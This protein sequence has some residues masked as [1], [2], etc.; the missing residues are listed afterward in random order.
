MSTHDDAST[1]Q[2]H[3][4]NIDSEDIS[5]PDGVVIDFRSESDLVQDR[6]AAHAEALELEEWY[7]E[8]MDEYRYEMGERTAE[9]RDDPRDEYDKEITRELMDAGLLEPPRFVKPEKLGTYETVE[10]GGGLT[11]SEVME[12]LV[13]YNERYNGQRRETTAGVRLDVGRFND[14]ARHLFYR[15]KLNYLFGKGGSGKTNLLLHVAAE[16]VMNREYVVWL[17]FEEITPTELQE[18]MVHQGVP[19]A[20][21]YRYFLP[22]QVTETWAPEIQGRASLVVIDS[23]N[24]CMEFLGV[25]PMTDSGAITKLVTTYFN[26][27]RDL[28]PDMTG[29]VI[30]HVGLSA[31]AQ[32]RPSGHHSK[33][34]KFQGAVYRLAPMREGVEGDW[35]YSALYLAKDNKRKTGLRT[36]EK[37]GYVLMDSSGESGTLDVRI[38]AEEPTGTSHTPA[39]EQAKNKTANGAKDIAERILREQTRISDEDW[40]ALIMDELRA[41]NEG[42]E[43]P[44]LRVRMRKAVSQLKGAEVAVQDGDDWVYAPTVNP[45]PLG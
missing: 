17:I 43:D 8:T 9:L 6:E 36:G 28:N 10:I 44:A 45:I 3:V 19:E 14:S 5:G 37:A 16:F 7:W 4:E 21:V 11:H 31:N 1:G 30:D 23:A 32:D 40:R 35:G 20:L 34:D 27:Y 42:T 18:M 26:P 13:R 25:N 15:T 24:P 39:G 33:L 38:V 22:F 29:V 12:A 41:V 2:N